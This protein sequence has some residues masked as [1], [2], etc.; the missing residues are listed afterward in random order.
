MPSRFEVIPDVAADAALSLSDALG[1]GQGWMSAVQVNV[2]GLMREA[3]TLM[4]DVAKDLAG[5]LTNGTIDSTSLLRNA[6]DWLTN[7]SATLGNT[8][9]LASLGAVHARM[10]PHAR[11]ALLLAV[12]VWLFRELLIR[13][14]ARTLLRR[15]GHA[16][17]D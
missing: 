4:G 14:T 2:N 11:A 13:S 1:A 15:H 3:T 16:H 10:P 17:R 6:S 8:T 5:N 12:F 9:S 7:Q